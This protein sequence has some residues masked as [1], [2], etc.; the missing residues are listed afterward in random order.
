MAANWPWFWKI[1][2]RDTAELLWLAIYLPTAA[3][4]RTLSTPSNTPTGSKNSRKPRNSPLIFRKLTNLRKNS[5]CLERAYIW[6][7]KSTMWSSGRT[8]RLWA[9]GSTWTN[10]KLSP[11]TTNK[12]RVP[13]PNPKTH[14]LSPT[15]LPKEEIQQPSKM[16]SLQSKMLPLQ[17]KPTSAT[18]TTTP[19]PST[20]S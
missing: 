7:P 16:L 11:T 17:L 2:L 13:P 18:S 19:K 10:L 8:P 20:T 15:N 4:P 9:T 6:N 3:V 12:D 14:H 5:C 1:P